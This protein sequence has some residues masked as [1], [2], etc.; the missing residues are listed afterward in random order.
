MEEIDKIKLNNLIMDVT[1]NIHNLSQMEIDIVF[2]P[3]GSGKSTF[4]RNNLMDPK[5]VHVS[6]DE[7]IS[8]VYS[9]E[10]TVLDMYKR[11]RRIGTIFT[12]KLL[13]LKVS[14]IIEGTGINDDIIQYLQRLKEADYRINIYI[15]N[16]PL[17]ICIKRVKERNKLTTRKISIDAVKNAYNGLHSNKEK[18]SAHANDYIIVNMTEGYKFNTKSFTTYSTI[19]ENAISNNVLCNENSLERTSIEFARDNGGYLT[20]K[21]LEILQNKIDMDKFNV[22]ISTSVCEFKLNCSYDVPKWNTVE[23]NGNKVNKCAIFILKSPTI[24]II[25]S[26]NI[27]INTPQNN[28]DNYINNMKEIDICTIPE[29]TLTVFSPNELVKYKTYDKND[30]QLNYIFYAN[31]YPKSTKIKFSNVIKKQVQVY[32]KI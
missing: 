26:R 17:N 16:T 5:K 2:G 29:N 4:I 9:E 27:I 21:L 11:V 32:V 31:I 28:I 15:I 3:M 22:E 25:N 7:Y 19:L 18:F 1:N 12:D 8:D 6:I 13:E 10:Y 23:F 24:E 14:M 20:N 30:F